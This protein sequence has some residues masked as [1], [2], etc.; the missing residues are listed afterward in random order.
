M[1]GCRRMR[2]FVAQRM[3]AL[4]RLVRLKGRDRPSVML[5]TVNAALQRVPAQGFRGRAFARRRAGQHAG[6]GRRHQMARTQWIHPRFHR[7]RARR[8]RRARRHHRSLRA[9]HG[10]AGAARFLRRHAGNDSQFRSRDAAHHRPAARARP[11][12][13]R[14][15]PAHDRDH[16][17]LS[18]RLRRRLRRGF[19]RRP[20]LRRG[21]RRPPPSRHGALA[22]AV[23]RPARHALRLCAGL[24]DRAGAAGRG[25]R[26][27]AARPDHGLFRGAA[28][29]AGAARRRPALPA[30][31][32]RPALSRRRRMGR[33]GSSNR[34][35][36]GSRRS[37]CRTPRGR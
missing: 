33:S 1:T 10:R 14:R 18:H 29:G 8:I 12:A 20:A 21:Q 4:S 30:A 22:A 9:R 15:I 37:R 27:R 31:A 5:T 6:D 35:W 13:G 3:T 16:P 28:A 36:R 32:A 7:S 19:A 34:R 2:G 26:A 23:P 24:A 25:R 17:A 11:G